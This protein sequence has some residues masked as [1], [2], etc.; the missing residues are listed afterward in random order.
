MISAD[1]ERGIFCRHLVQ[2]LRVVRELG[3]ERLAGRRSGERRN[4]RYELVGE[5][6]HGIDVHPMIGV[7][8]TGE[9]LGRHVGG[10]ADRDSRRRNARERHRGTQCFGDAEVGDECV[11]SLRQEYLPA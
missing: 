7:R 8:I 1:S 11:R 5:Q 9:L 10:S 2:R 6:A 3:R 4:A